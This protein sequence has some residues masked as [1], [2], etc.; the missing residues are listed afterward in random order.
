MFPRTRKL[1]LLVAAA[2][3]LAGTGL[4]WVYLDR[5]EQRV[6]GGMPVPVLVVLEPMG[7]GTVL[8]DSQLMVR[9][10]P[11]A[12]VEDRF[13]KAVDRRK[14]I[15]LRLGRPLASQQ[16]L[17]WDDLE[18]AGTAAR[19]VSGLVPAGRRAMP[20]RLSWTRAGLRLIRPGDH[21]DV[22]ASLPGHQAEARIAVVLLQKALV[23]A[24]GSETRRDGFPQRMGW[25]GDEPIVT[26]S[27]SLRQAQLL[28]LAMESGTLQLA[29][30]NPD[31]MRVTPDV[32]SVPSELLLEPTGRAAAKTDD[33]RPIRLRT[34]SP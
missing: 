10:I 28:S 6:S 29:L 11:E 13:V 27:V 1:V 17:C 5:Y 20:V 14:I 26:L 23:L 22:I 31:D 4:L 8:E 18:Q 9:E 7:R 25:G 2:T 33:P 34:T 32:Q 21:V 30:R 12:Y 24:V 3:A 16:T 19:D 15:G